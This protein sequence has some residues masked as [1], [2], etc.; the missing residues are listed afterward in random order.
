MLFS[1]V[2]TFLRGDRHLIV[3]SVLFG[4]LFSGLGLIPPLL[5][6]E[7]ILR[8]QA[9][10]MAGRSFLLLGTLVL[11]VYLLRGFCRY[12]YGVFSHVAAYRTLHR[13]MTTVYQHLQRQ[14][15]GFYTR[16]QSG[17]L[18]S[19]SV[20][21]IEA[22]EDFIAHGIPETLLAIVIPV[23]MA[24]VLFA[25]NAKLALVV[26]LP[27]PV[28]AALVYVV[29]MSTKRY[30]RGVRR[31]IADVVARVQD[32]FSGM[33]EIQS[34]VRET[35]KAHEVCRAS[36]ASRDCIIHANRWS[37][38]PAGVIET[39]SGAGL[40]LVVWYGGVL[41]ERGV[42]AV[43]DLVVF[44]MY[45][46]QIF[47]PFLRLANL[48]EN[49]QKAAASAERVFALLDTEPTIVDAPGAGAPRSLRW[50]VEF[51]KVTFGYR[52]DRL[53]LRDVS[54]SVEPGELV[55]LVGPTGVGKTTA[56]K[57]VPRFYDVDGGAVRV[58]GH[59]VRELKLDFLRRHVA[60]VLQDVFLFHGTVRENLLVG[61][62]EA[63]DDALREAARVANAEE[64]ILKLPE[65][66]DTPIGERG[67]RLSGGQKQRLSIA[68]AILKD[69]PVL[70]LDEATSAVDAE[71]EALIQEALARLVAGR[72]VLVIAHRLSTIRN[73]D[74]I[75]V[76]TEGRVDEV[77]SH[78]ELMAQDGY[79]ARM[80]RL[81]AS[82]QT[83]QIG[84]GQGT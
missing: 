65:Q 55:A 21:D 31:R 14:P 28:V 11:A 63:D 25:I 3:L 19:R 23:A 60:M 58:G 56:T 84:A 53:V 47:L 46:G 79:Y 10:S 26:L 6:R 75:V 18:V 78:D 38:V 17:N 9:P 52:R 22:I 39:A 12:L 68:R 29:M 72:T 77:G 42:L 40:V 37:L 27:L 57:L 44:L 76:L 36:E 5:I 48:T 80:S 74:R 8:M 24:C 62:P 2:L 64:F 73:A 33:A 1:R 20:G 49:L 51:G 71:T 15:A 35:E 41:S 7:M 4:L 16:E 83:W 30:W 66:Y 45:L 13:L 32:N 70:I 50:D 61:C 54:F 67:V 81:Q 34:F 59:D 43:A 82:A 69:A